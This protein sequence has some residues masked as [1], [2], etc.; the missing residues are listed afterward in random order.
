VD[1]DFMDQLGCR[2]IPFLDL[3]IHI[4]GGLTP[5]KVA[6]R[7]AVTGMGAGVLR[8]IGKG[9]EIE[10][11]E[12]L[13]EF[14]DSAAGMP[15]LVGLQVNDR[16]WLHR[17]SPELL[18][19]LDYVLADTMIMPMPNDDSPMVKLWV[20]DQYKIDDPE[21]WMQRYVRHNLRVLSEPITVL[22]NPTYLPPSVADQ[23][24]QLW[25]DERMCQVIEAALDN[26]VALEI[27]ASSPWPHDRFIRMAKAMGAKFTFG[28][29]NFDDKP[30]NMQRCLEAVA[31]YDLTA[32]E[33]WVPSRD[34]ALIAIHEATQSLTVVASSVPRPALKSAASCGAASRERH[35]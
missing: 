29:N 3:H 22:A 20:A 18:Q 5:A 19:R 33:L 28:S 11:D 34:K 15:L 12:Q 17:H 4:R 27:N 26:H 25:T 35:Q 1:P 21:A 9:W 30:I 6:D 10:T 8:N 7:Q 23:Y 14:L 31:R 16:D 13:R 32:K 24:D 2:S